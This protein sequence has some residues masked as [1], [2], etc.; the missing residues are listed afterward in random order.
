MSVKT[1]YTWTYLF[2]IKSTISWCSLISLSDFP[3]TPKI[4]CW[5]QRCTHSSWHFQVTRSTF[6]TTYDKLFVSFFCMQR[7]RPLSL[8]I[9]SIV[10]VV[11]IIVVSATKVYKG[12]S[13]FS[14]PPPGF[15][16]VLSKRCVNSLDTNPL[17]LENII[18]RSL[19]YRTGSSSVIRLD[20][21]R[22]LQID[23]FIIDLIKIYKR[24]V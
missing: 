16:Y 8:K 21:K 24:I 18:R 14:V 6:Q 7:I 3:G 22:H 11:G 5:H 9:K 4:C 17:S 12:S 19:G 2:W 20:G 1:S 10:T 15:T 23:S 13:V